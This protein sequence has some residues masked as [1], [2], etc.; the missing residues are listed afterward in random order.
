LSAREFEI[1]TRDAIYQGF[2]SLECLT[3][4]HTLFKGGW[5]GA[6]S[7]ELFRSNNC[8]AVLLYDPD[9]DKV[10]LLEQF[11][12]G[13]SLNSRRAWL[14][15]IVGGGIE[16]GE[17][18]EQVAYRETIEEAGCEII[19]L[20]E[21]MSFYTTPGSSSEHIMLFCARVDSSAIGGIH[22]LQEEGED[23]LV[24]AIDAGDV[25][26]MLEK[27]KIESAISIVAI[28]WLYIHREKLRKQWLAS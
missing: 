19:D 17:T 23:I 13:A 18:P 5:S 15:E 25:F 3:V 4:R 27:R 11:R 9:L 12:V 24:T 8:V 14:L 1:L 28:Q 6:I 16:E 21:I 26:D 20:I 7:R 10:V 22:G 2:F